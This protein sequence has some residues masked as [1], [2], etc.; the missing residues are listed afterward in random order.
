MK[1]QTL[2][3]LALCLLGMFVA[4]GCGG[5]DSSTGSTNA[6]SVSSADGEPADSGA[7]ALTKAQ[8]I[9]RGDAIC[10]QADKEQTTNVAA[11]VK[12]HPN[13]ES[14]AG[15]IQL[16][17]V[18]GLP[19]LRVEWEE[20][21]ALNP[22]ASDEAEV[23]AI[24]DGIKLATAKAE[25]DPASVLVSPSPY[26]QVGKLAGKYGFKVCSDAL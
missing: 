24:V 12:K 25:E 20:L 8:F 14:K 2:I 23:E 10:A 3:A 1:P 15:Q 21:A 11:Y 6:G 22:P 13:S 7:V 26:A 19:P 17:L 9:K 16:V 18:A 4:G 5:G